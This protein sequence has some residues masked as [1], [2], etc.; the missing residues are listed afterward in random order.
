MVTVS[1]GPS[2][3][4]RRTDDVD[5][6]NTNAALLNVLGRKRKEWMN[7]AGSR[8]NGEGAT[9]QTAVAT[10]NGHAGPSIGSHDGRENSVSRQIAER[11]SDA[12]RIAAMANANETGP[13][14]QPELVAYELPLGSL[15]AQGPT[16]SRSGSV[17]RSTTQPGLPSP[18][19]SEDNTNTPAVDTRRKPGWPLGKPRGPRNSVGTAST[20]PAQSPSMQNQTRPN[21]LFIS[22][23]NQQAR[24]H[25]HAHQSPGM[26]APSTTTRNLTSPFV[27]PSGDP[28]RR[29]VSAQSPLQIMM[30]F[31]PPIQQ[32]LHQQQAFCYRQDTMIQRLN[33][34]FRKMDQHCSTTDLGRKQLLHDAIW[35]NDFFYLV[36]SHV[37]C[38]RSV[39]P[40]L[41]PRELG[42]LPATSWQA[43]ET[44]L[45]SNN[46]VNPNVLRFFA[47]FPEPI[48]YIYASE[49]AAAFSKQLGHIHIFLSHLPMQWDPLLRTS[50][51]RLAPPLAQDLV[52]GMHLSSVVLQ[53]T[54][55][56]A[57]VRS[58]PI[59]LDDRSMQFLEQLNREDQEGYF[60]RHWR[61]A[62]VE[63]YL[64][65]NV[66]ALVIRK[67]VEW[68]SMGGQLSAFVVPAETAYFRQPPLAMAG[69]PGVASRQTGLTEA[70]QRQLM[71]I[72]NHLLAQQQR[73]SVIAPQPFALAPTHSWQQQTSVQ[74][75][76]APNMPPRTGQRQ[77][78]APIQM[79][80][81]RTH[82]HPL[83]PREGDPARAQPVAPDTNRMAL[84]QAHLRSPIPGPRQLPPQ[85]QPLYRHVIGY[86]LNLTRIN[87]S[88]AAQSVSF[89][90]SQESIDKIPK[91]EPAKL[92]GE[93]GVRI[94]NEQS[95]LHRLRC[96]AIPKNGFQSENQWVTAD[97][98]WPDDLRMEINGHHLE[99]RRKLHHG[100]Y[101]PIDVSSYLKPDENE[102]TLYL[103]RTDNR[104]F[105][106]AVA[107]ETVGVQSHSDIIGNIPT[108]S[109]TDSLKAIKDSLAAS[110]DDDDDIVMTSSALT[111]GLF[112][113]FTADR[114]SSIPVRGKACLHR[115][116]FDLETFLNQ[117]KREKPGWPT[118][119]DCWR[120]PICKADV[121][122][123]EMIKDGFLIEVRREL[124]KKGLMQTRAIVVEADGSWRPK[125]EEKATGIRSPSLER[126]E[127]VKAKKPPVEVIE[128]D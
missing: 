40:N 15:A 26:Q 90:V 83:L 93:P 69:T 108:I 101:L 97:N 62:Q 20:S 84:H 117:C 45:C 122:P 60:Q 114:I 56:R 19:P 3:K 120:C 72:N 48:Q 14:P 23:A 31:Q 87:E 21:P 81:S 88:L 82:S 42:N 75:P 112:D 91:T 96:S 9:Q 36:L 50:Q 102:L 64:L 17:Q 27:L 126:E 16:A 4:R 13:D 123:Q 106:Y 116:C 33:E 57:V 98:V 41:L 74:T 80:G 113:P 99:P 55:F 107:I 10:P 76:G 65:Y 29:S 7:G 111:I 6:A 79:H 71:E 49:T 103:L 25:G 53:T 95:Q 66:Y 18:A 73:T 67:L 77:H 54:V 105:D 38:L 39:T 2:P 24:Q 109:A 30:P 125:P 61:K 110:T 115:D 8:T 47:T 52:E 32:Q 63:N 85:A 127:S 104:A 22:T 28:P 86:A 12:N 94:L 59:S 119:V 100:R 11:S 89:T 34:Y 118:V 43:L 46:D 70:Q 5:V 92:K 78:N 121:R 37:F 128:L 51:Q 68:R 35:R 58:F 124:E 1:G 44:L